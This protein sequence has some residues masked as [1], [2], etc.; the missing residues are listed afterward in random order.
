MDV[1]QIFGDIDRTIQRHGL[2]QI[3]QHFL[4]RQA[5]AQA[6]AVGVFGLDDNDIVGGLDELLGGIKHSFIIADKV[7]TD[8]AAFLTKIAIIIDKK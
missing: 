7:F 8:T 1:A 4:Q 6:V 2:A 3:A 5:R